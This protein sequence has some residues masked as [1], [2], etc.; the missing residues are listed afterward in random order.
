MVHLDTILE[1]L[2]EACNQSDVLPDAVTYSTVVLDSGGAHS[3][4]SPP[5]IEFSVDSIDRLHNRNTEK[6]GKTFDDNG[7]Q[8]GF[9]Y[10]QWFDAIVTAEVFSVAET[11]YNHRELEQQLRKALYAY[12]KHGMNYSLPDP[13]SP[14][15]HLNDVSKLSYRGATPDQ[16]FNFQPSVRTRNVDIDVEFV[17]EITTKD[18]GITYETIEDVE[19]TIEDVDDSDANITAVV[20]S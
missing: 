8:D 3:N 6:V 18:L 14:S 11:S 2:V 7:V 15:E 1:G 5:I 10:T 9:R 16:N 12:D 19:F 20:T 4:V 13:A 17:H